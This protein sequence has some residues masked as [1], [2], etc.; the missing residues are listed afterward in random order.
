MLEQQQQQPTTPEYPSNLHCPNCGK[1]RA[2]KPKTLKTVPTETRTE[3]FYVCSN[4][5]CEFTVQKISNQESLHP[6]FKTLEELVSYMSERFDY[7]PR[8]FGNVKDIINTALDEYARLK[9]LYHAMDQ[10]M[11]SHDNITP[12]DARQ[13]EDISINL[14]VAQQGPERDL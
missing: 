13:G 11:G 1:D 8:E 14:S 4:C 6:T 10:L 5:N 12:F 7:S 2:W 9:T 3:K